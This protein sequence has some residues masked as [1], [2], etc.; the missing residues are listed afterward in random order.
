MK[1]YALALLSVTSGTPCQA[2]VL[3]SSQD[4][5]SFSF[6]QRGSVGEFMNFFT[7]TVA[8]RTPPNQPSSV[9][10]NNYKAHVFRNASRTPGGLSLAAVMITDLEYPYRPAFSLLTKLLD[11]NAGLLQQLP[12]PSAAPSLAAASASAFGG[13]PSQNA[14]GGL[15]PAQKGKLEGTLATYLAK[16]QDPKQADTIMKVQAELDET[17]IVLHKTIESVLERG[18]K[19][20]N[21]VERSNALS[22]QS[23]MFYKTAKKA[24]SPKRGPFAFIS[25]LYLCL[26]HDTVGD[27]TKIVVLSDGSDDEIVYVSSPPP[28]M[29]VRTEST[30]TIQLLEW[31]DSEGSDYQDLSTALSRFSSTTASFRSASI[32]HAGPSRAPKRKLAS[33]SLAD[34]SPMRERPLKASRLALVTVD[35]NQPELEQSRSRA[36]SIRKA[37]KPS[38]ENEFEGI[39]EETPADKAARKEAEKIKR[40]Q[41]RAA[42]KEV[43]KTQ[44]KYDREAAKAGKEAEKSY[45]KKL[46]DANRLRV[47]KIDALREIELHLAYDLSLPSSPIASA[48]PEVKMRLEDN[49]SSL[50][51]LTE[52]ETVADGTVRFLR[53]VKAKWDPVAKRFIPLDVERLEWEPTLVVVTTVDGIVDRLAQN[54]DMF[55]EWLSDIQLAVTNRAD[56]QVFLLVRGLAK[57]HSKTD[58]IVNRTY[59]DNVNAALHDGDARLAR[60]E[61]GRRVTKDMVEMQLLRAQIEQHIFVVLVDET[62]V[63]EDW[64]Y[65]LSA[66]VAFRPYKKLTKSHLAFSAPVGQRKGAEPSSVLELM[67]Q[68]V[69]GLTAAAALGVS[70]DY[71]SLRK[72]M[73]AYEEDD[74]GAS[75]LAGCSVGSLATGV[76]TSR[77]LGPALSK[78]VYE[79]MRGDDPLALL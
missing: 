21:L 25:S 57:Y 41:E 26:N 70:K 33:R 2:T 14:Q 43:E 46:A 28:R 59:R 23:K 69:P 13:N 77:T 6:Y 36:K 60:P 48:M 18:E 79:I 29:V 76:A 78:K 61:I 16:Y 54:E 38:K 12:N 19:L 63:I 58:S 31:S 34:L 17:K 68:E 74:D 8:E 11:E 5:S 39:E 55:M 62:E 66:D 52:E 47:S 7:K 51:Y 22:S 49:Q 73:E 3:G 9:E 30:A 4:L 72:L 24:E 20:D 15:P 67:L 44:K 40:Q 1:V 42:A 75:L 71:P 35:E 56:E 64:L 27:I 10:E 37:R 50:H 32:T 65:N 45:Q 53:R